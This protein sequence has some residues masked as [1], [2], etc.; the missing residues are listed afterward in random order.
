MLRPASHPGTPEAGFRRS[1]PPRP[2]QDQ[3][4]GRA[5]LGVRAEAG[6]RL[7]PQT[8]RHEGLSEPVPRGEDARSAWFRAED[9]R[10]REELLVSLA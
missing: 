6:R 4:F 10:I 3:S 2:V 8:V 5:N 1:K 7:L 9:R